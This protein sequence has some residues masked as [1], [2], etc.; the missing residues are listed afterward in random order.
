MK[1]VHPLERMLA[2]TTL[3]RHVASR[4]E[5]KTNGMMRVKA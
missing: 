4:H 1:C 2:S 3:S 5:S